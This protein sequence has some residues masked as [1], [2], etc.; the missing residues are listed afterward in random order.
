[1]VGLQVTNTG[2]VTGSKTVKVDAG[3][4]GSESRLQL[5][6]A[7]ETVVQRFTFPTGAGDAGTYDI[8]ATTGD[9]SASTTATVRPVDDGDAEFEVDIDDTRVNVSSPVLPGPLPPVDS[10]LDLNVT[11]EADYTVANTGNTSDTQDVVFTVDD[12]RQAS[13]TASL[14]A[15]ER[16]SG[17]FSTTLSVSD[18]QP[19]DRPCIVPHGG[20]CLPHVTVVVST[21]DDRASEEVTVGPGGGPMPTVTDNPPL[22]LDG[23]GLHEDIRGDGEQ[24]ILDVQGLFNEVAEAE[25]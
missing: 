9:D 1:V 2:D 8:S 18:I 6:G 20:A 7:G 19:P 14:G 15:G 13:E 10:T 16:A 24:N 12:E 3:G 21:D 23:D 25:G 5:L 17:T 4:L 11:L 22:D